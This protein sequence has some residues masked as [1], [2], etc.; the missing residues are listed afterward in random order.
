MDILI[1]I[2]INSH[3]YNNSL[4]QKEALRQSKSKILLPDLG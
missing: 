2:N 4:S 1:H 3:T